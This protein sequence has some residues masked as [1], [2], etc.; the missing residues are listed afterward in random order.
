LSRPHE[1]QLD[2][3]SRVR[4]HPDHPE[5]GLDA[6]RVVLDILFLVVVAAVGWMVLSDFSPAIMVYVG[7]RDSASARAGNS[8]VAELRH[9]LSPSGIPYRVRIEHTSGFEDVRQTSR[10]RSTESRLVF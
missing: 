8:V 10:T 7:P 4:L 1:S 6:A 9:T 2:H 3:S 5:S